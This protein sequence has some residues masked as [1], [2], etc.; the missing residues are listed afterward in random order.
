MPQSLEASPAWRRTLRFTREGRIFVVM[1]VGI[2]IAAVNTGSNLLFLLLC[3][4]LSLIVLSG[5][6]SERSIS[7]VHVTHSLPEAFAGN[8]AELVW[9]VR[10]THPRPSYSLKLEA[11]FVGTQNPG[12]A[13]QV[14]SAS[15]FFNIPHLEEP[16]A[17]TS[18]L[19]FPTRG[20]YRW[21]YTKIS[22]QFPFGLFEKSR[23][24]AQENRPPLRVYPKPMPDPKQFA[25]LLDASSVVES[26]TEQNKRGNDD[27]RSVKSFERGDRIADVLWKR[28]WGR[29]NLLSKERGN[30]ADAIELFFDPNLA[31]ELEPKISALTALVLE[32]TKR[33]QTLIV[34]T[35][36]TRFV[37]QDPPSQKRLLAW[38]ATVGLLASTEKNA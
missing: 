2:G 4:L 37:V 31:E 11:G 27:P 8:P 35:P 3:F 33:Q 26:H 14:T 30:N 12:G 16:K 17:Q 28:S 36:D 1:V 13:H 23:I 29:T 25:D 7:N 24:L 9:H 34:K 19:T 21:E 5:I 15:Y 32:A 6:L 18:N 10:T 20:M 38:L 22:T